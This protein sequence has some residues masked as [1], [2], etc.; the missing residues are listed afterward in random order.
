MIRSVH[1]SAWKHGVSENDA[2]Y[3]LTNMVYEGYL[4]DGNPARRL[5]LGFDPEGAL[6]ELVVLIFD[7]GNELVIHAM[8]ARK[9]Y[10]RLLT[11]RH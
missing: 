9:Q 2:L 6:L 8:P 10:L 1:A 3:A 11:K 7:S 4:N 5:I